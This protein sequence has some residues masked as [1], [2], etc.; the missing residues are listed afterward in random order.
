MAFAMFLGL[1]VHELSGFELGPLC[2]PETAVT[3]KGT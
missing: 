3:Q 2:F 1:A